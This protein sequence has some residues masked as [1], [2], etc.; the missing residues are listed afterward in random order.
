MELASRPARSKDSNSIFSLFFTFNFDVCVGVAQSS[1][2]QPSLANP[3]VELSL[4]ALH[5]KS[6]GRNLIGLAWVTCSLKQLL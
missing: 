5:N 4:L 6:Q 3:K 1:A 2:H